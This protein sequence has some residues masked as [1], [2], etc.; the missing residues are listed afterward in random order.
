MTEPTYLGSREG[1]GDRRQQEL[2][3]FVQNIKDD[4]EPL[5]QRKEWLHSRWYRDEH[6]TTLLDVAS[7]RDARM[8][9]CFLSRD[10]AERQDVIRR[11][12]AEGHE[13][14]TH[15]SRHFLINERHDHEFLHDDLS[16]C[17]DQL[18]GLGVSCKGMWLSAHGKLDGDRAADA[19]R[20][21][22]LEWFSSGIE[23]PEADL[24]DG[25]RFVPQLDPH[26]FALLI[27]SPEPLEA[28]RVHWDEMATRSEHG[29]MLFHPFSLTMI[30]DDITE[31]WSDW[32]R[33]VGGS[34]PVDEFDGST[35]RPS[36]VLDCS[37]HLHMM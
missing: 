18:A 15:G 3:W 6:F 14:A 32:L 1:L 33:S 7:A 12:V 27:D 16:E 37:L 34:V 30:S 4:D 10:V 17:I 11:M 26:D 8:T 24:P 31:M 5:R 13:V 2:E 20:D 35:G 25:L 29:V 36:I 22:G 21:V 28:V 23:H 19:L 9:F